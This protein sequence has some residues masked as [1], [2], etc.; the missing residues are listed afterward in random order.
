VKLWNFKKA[1]DN[2]SDVAIQVTKLKQNNYMKKYGLFEFYLQDIQ[3]ML[4]V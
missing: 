2:Y 3:I 1:M 4:F